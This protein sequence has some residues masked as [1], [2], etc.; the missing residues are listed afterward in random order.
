[1]TRSDERFL[2]V[3]EY[4]RVLVVVRGDRGALDA[5]LIDVRLDQD[6]EDVELETPL[7]AFAAKMVDVLQARGTEGL[8]LSPGLRDMMVKEKAAEDLRRIERAARRLH[9]TET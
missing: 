8:G 9:G 7:R 3:T 1:M 4:G 2:V 6:A 5:D